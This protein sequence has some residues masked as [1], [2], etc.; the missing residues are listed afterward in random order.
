MDYTSILSIIVIVLFL[1][2]VY[3]LMRR[4]ISS[5][6]YDKMYGINT[7]GLRNWDKDKV[8][9]RTESTPYPALNSFVKKYKMNDGDGLVDFGCGKGRVAIYLHHEYNIS[10]T[11][12]ELNDLTYNE[13]LKNVESY[14]SKQ[15]KLNDD[16]LKI[17]Q[18]YAEDY[19]IKE[20]ENKFFFFNPFHI[21]I[22]KKVVHN[23]LA[24]AKESNKEVEIILYYPLKSYRRFLEEGTPFKLVQEISAAGSIGYREKFLIYKLTP[25]KFSKT[26]DR[27]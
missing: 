14:L 9:N 8:Y 5:I 18:E 1:Y 22:F 19:R 6:R 16:T 4:G 25:L 24:D 26:V 21:S 13:A 3:L 11:G 27:V 20:N 2:C 23:I 12:V 10:V 15:G 17:E 7:R